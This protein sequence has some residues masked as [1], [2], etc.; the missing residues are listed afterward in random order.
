MAD[1]QH[2]VERIG[3]VAFEYACQYDWATG[4]AFHR[5]ENKLA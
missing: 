5:K 3:V 1:C 4:I 2:G